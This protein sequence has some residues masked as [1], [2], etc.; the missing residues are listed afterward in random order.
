MQPAATTV[1]HNI[2]KPD[3]STVY[4]ISRKTAVCLSVCLN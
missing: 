3:Y 2:N 1:T 4:S